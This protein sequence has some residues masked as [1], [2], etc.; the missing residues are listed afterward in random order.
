[1]RREVDYA[2]CSWRQ[3]GGVAGLFLGQGSDGDDIDASHRDHS[4]E[5]ALGWGHHKTGN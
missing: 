4:I 5:W 1:M 3:G 2:V